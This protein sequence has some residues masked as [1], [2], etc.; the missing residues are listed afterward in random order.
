M[1]IDSINGRKPDL[2]A[3]KTAPKSDVD[4]SQKTANSSSVKD[5]S[6]AIT[7]AAQEIKKAF[8]SSPETAVDVNRVASIKK[9]IADGSYTIDAEKVAQKMIQF[10]KS[11]LEDNSS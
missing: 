8:G 6:V 7:D 5:D 3:I 11:F 4:S 2:P 10:E 9:A 1:A